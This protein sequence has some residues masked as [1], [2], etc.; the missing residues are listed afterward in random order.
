M[1]DPDSSPTQSTTEADL[2]AAMRVVYRR[3]QRWRGERKGRERI[4]EALWATAGELAREYG[5]AP[6]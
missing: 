1:A 5:A 2:P 3:L 6:R 4:A